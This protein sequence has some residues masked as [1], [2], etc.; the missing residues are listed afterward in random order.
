MKSQE[1]LNSLKNECEDLNKKLC[2]LSEDELKEVTGGI[3]FLRCKYDMV[4]QQFNLWKGLTDL[5]R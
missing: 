2:E 5:N 3:D 4:F 1:E